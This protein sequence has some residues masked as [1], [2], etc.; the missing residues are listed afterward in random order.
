[1]FSDN[2]ETAA[3]SIKVIT[4]GGLRLTDIFNSPYWSRQ[5]KGLARGMSSAK[6]HCPTKKHALKLA[7]DRRC[8]WREMA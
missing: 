6:S 5:Q 2:R 4:R 1:M 7:G 3:I 8:F